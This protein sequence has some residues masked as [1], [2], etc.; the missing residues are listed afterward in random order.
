M[1]SS[2]QLAINKHRT[3]ATS[4]NVARVT[5]TPS[6]CARLELLLGAES[7]LSTESFS[8]EELPLCLGTAGKILEPAP[9]LPIRDKGPT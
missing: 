2:C 7:L 1:P 9:G 8:E 4:K 5:S 6:R 3:T